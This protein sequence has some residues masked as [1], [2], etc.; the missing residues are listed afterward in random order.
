[1]TETEKRGSK[2]HG[3]QREDEAGPSLPRTG[4]LCHHALTR[5]LGRQGERVGGMGCA[6]A[7][8][9]FVCHDSCL[10]K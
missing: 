1:M 6:R 3:L 10:S 2:N 7:G 8:P 5:K 9:L 4:G